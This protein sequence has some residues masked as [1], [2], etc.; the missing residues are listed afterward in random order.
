MT[1]GQSG[2]AYSCTDPLEVLD[3]DSVDAIFVL[4]RH[5]L[6]ADAVREAI[7]RGKHV[8]VEKPL[9]ISEEDLMR[10]DE[11]Q[12]DLGD[13][14]P[15]VMVGFN[16]RFTR[17]TND[18]KSLFSGISAPTIHMRM[19]TAELPASFWV[20][21]PE[22]GGGRIVGEACHAIDTCVAIAGSPPI[23][24]YAESAGAPTSDAPT[25]DRVV[26][27]MRHANGALSS[28]SYQAGGA[29]SGPKGTPRDHGWWDH[30]HL[31]RLGRRT[32]LGR[33]RTP[34]AQGES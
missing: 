27:T 22:V 15:V 8:F 20:H 33:S 31:R 10:L 28:V 5:H 3:D 18:I 16:R 26:I 11:Q 30:R 4:T 17:A 14:A 23:K 21:D 29:R 6:H 24:V 2:F 34:K 25:E 12:R 32:H 1:G 19:V 9:V 13:E 7:A